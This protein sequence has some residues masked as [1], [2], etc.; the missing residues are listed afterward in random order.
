LVLAAYFDEK[1][2]LDGWWP[3]VV[4]RVEDGKYVLTWRDAPNDPHFKSSRKFL[5]ILHPE[6]LTS[7]IRK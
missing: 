4:R 2:L 1:Q 3:A 7:P 6:Y 5:A